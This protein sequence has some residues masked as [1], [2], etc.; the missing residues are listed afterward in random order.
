MGV[1]GMGVGTKSESG[2]ERKVKLS[3]FFVK[4]VVRQRDAIVEAEGCASHEHAQAE[5]EIIVITDGIEV[6][7]VGVD[8]AP[9][10]EQREPHG[11]HDIGG[12][13]D[14]HETI[15]FAAQD[16]AGSRIMW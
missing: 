16:I 12:I 1:M 6:V 3:A 2:T 4:F 13:L 11:A 7:S 9:I 5:A 14:A 10:V 15:G 8:E